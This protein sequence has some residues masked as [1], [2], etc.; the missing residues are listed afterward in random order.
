MSGGGMIGKHSLAFV[1]MVAGGLAGVLGAYI[2][3]AATDMLSS[4]Q[5]WAAAAA[6]AMTGLLLG[7]FMACFL[8]SCNPVKMLKGLQAAGAKLSYWAVSLH[9]R[10]LWGP[11]SGWGCGYEPEQG[12]I[13]MG[14]HTN[15]MGHV[16]Q[17]V[18]LIG[19]LAKA[20][21]EVDTVAF[22]DMSKV[23]QNFLDDFK[24]IMPGVHLYDFAH[25]IHY[26][27]NL[28]GEVSLLKVV[29]NTLWMI[30]GPPGLS[31]VRKY[32]AMLKERRFHVCL[33]LWDP[34]IPVLHDS[35]WGA[36]KLK[37]VNVATQGLLYLEWPYHFQL[38]FLWYANM[39]S[40]QLDAELISLLFFPQHDALPVI[41][42]VPEQKTKEDFLLAYSCMP[43]ALTEIAQIKDKKVVLFTKAVERWTEYYKECPNIEIKKVGA[44]F[45]GYLSRCSGLIA[46]PS[47]GVVTQ[48]LAVGTPCYLI[49]PPGHLEQ[50][51]NEDYYFKYF[52]GVTNAERVPL[53]TWASGVTKSDKSLMQQAKSVREWLLQFDAQAEKLV[54][55]AMRRA[56]A[57]GDGGGKKHAVGSGAYKSL[58]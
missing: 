39:G 57:S 30:M 5:L 18:R 40:I 44:E 19:A 49:C 13:V 16:I 10:M 53:T 52:V 26:D 7:I 37:V 23:P 9:I 47:P 36:Q 20:G 21:I 51:F 31:M 58:V 35:L 24:R 48:A 27:D 4:S 1:G 15:G 17:A 46:S 32:V 29:L 56:M 6:G 42:A 41:V 12:K 2:S 55:P 43:A 28:G 25:E 8:V 33:S 14:V 11:L 38:D 54:I 3:L 50:K 22:G 45:A 34:H